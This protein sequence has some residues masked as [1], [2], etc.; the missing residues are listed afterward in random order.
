MYRCD[1]NSHAP[2]YNF[3]VSRIDTQEFRVVWGLGEVYFGYEEL[4]FALGAAYFEQYP[5]A[6]LLAAFG[7]DHVGSGLEDILAGLE[8]EHFDLQ[9]ISPYTDPSQEEQ[10]T[11]GQST[12][13]P[14]GGNN[15]SPGGGNNGSGSN[16][17]SSPGGVGPGGALSG[18]TWG[19][20]YSV[21]SL[22]HNL[23]DHD[24]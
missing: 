22:L 16:S 10:D 8:G 13:S 5:S 23:T 6:A 7:A 9:P 19:A 21:G 18:G 17:G 1:P 14:E 24:H 12:H 11:D 3:A 15:D 4:D 2:L 20:V